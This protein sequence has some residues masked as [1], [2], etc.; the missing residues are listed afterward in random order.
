MICVTSRSKKSIF[1]SL[2]RKSNIVLLTVKLGNIFNMGYKVARK[3]KTMGNIELRIDGE[4]IVLTSSQTAQLKRAVEKETS[5]LAPK[6]CGKISLFCKE[7]GN[8]GSFP[9]VIVSSYKV[10][11]AWGVGNT[12]YGRDF[13]LVELKS[14]IKNLKAYAAQIWTTAEKELKNV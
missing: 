9:L 8:K 6:T 13:S 12:L 10:P 3:D 4:I 7:G 5:V 11:C 14:F 2:G 1:K